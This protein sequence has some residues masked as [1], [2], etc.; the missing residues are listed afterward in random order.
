MLE[1][2]LGAQRIN[3]EIVEADAAEG[4][5][6]RRTLNTVSAE[7]EAIEQQLQIM[8]TLDEFKDAEYIGAPPAQAASSSHLN[9]VC[10]PYHHSPWGS[11]SV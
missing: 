5:S 10:L 2:N 6:L 9:T 3:T 7:K 1:V 4:D 11:V 8:S